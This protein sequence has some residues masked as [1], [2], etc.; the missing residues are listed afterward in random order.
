MD[1]PCGSDNKESA[2][3]KGY[4]GLIL[5]SGK[6]ARE[7]NG[8]PFQYSCLENPKDRGGHKL[9]DTNGQHSRSQHWLQE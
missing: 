7:E 9:L 4:P 2:G 3:N 6:S 1:F 8:N 5:G